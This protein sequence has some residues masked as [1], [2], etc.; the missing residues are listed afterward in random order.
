MSH[1][2]ELGFIVRY[3]LLANR[4]DVI[5]RWQARPSTERD[6][7]VPL[8][9][10][11]VVLQGGFYKEEPKIPRTSPATTSAL[12]DQGLG[13]LHVS[14]GQGSFESSPDPWAE[15]FGENELG[16][17]PYT[18]GTNC[19]GTGG[20]IGFQSPEAWWDHFRRLPPEPQGQGD[21]FSAF[22]QHQ[23]PLY[24]GEGEVEDEVQEPED[25]YADPDDLVYEPV[26]YTIPPALS[27]SH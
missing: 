11:A 2:F 8:G 9:S 15:W 1:E 7:D 17:L 14:S 21:D 19:D 27:G 23:G 26:P 20:L 13:G 3:K 16:E 10:N 6:R 5:T 24:C 25:T 22:G 18:Y 12:F 4:D